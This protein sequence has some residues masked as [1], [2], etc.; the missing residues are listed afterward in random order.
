MQRRDIQRRRRPAQD[1]ARFAVELNGQTR[2]IF[3]WSRSEPSR[4]TSGTDS[5]LGTVRRGY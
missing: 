2:T 5:A 3:L 4:L 1:R